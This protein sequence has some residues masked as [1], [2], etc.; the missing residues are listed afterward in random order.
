MEVSKIKQIQ[1]HKLTYYDYP[2]SF[3][4]ETTSFRDENED[5][6]GVM[7]IWQF[8][9]GD[10]E[11]LI[12]GRTWEE[13]DN[14]IHLLRKQFHLSKY[15]ILI[16]Y[17]HN[18]T[19]EMQWIRKRF[20]WEKIFALEERVPLFMRTDTG[21]EFRCSYKLSNASLENLAKNLLFHEI[22]KKVGDLDYSKIRNSET[23]LTEKEMDYCMYDVRIVCAYIAERIQAD[24]KITNIPL[25]ST[26]YV[27]NSCRIACYGTDYSAPKYYNYRDM[28]KHITMEV[29]EYRMIKAAFMGGYCH[30]NAYYVRHTLENVT[31]F[32]FT[33]SYPYVLFS[34][35]YPWTKGELCY[36]SLETV[37]DKR[38]IYGWILDLEI[39]GL[40]S[41]IMQDDYLS[42]SKCIECRGYVLNNGRINYADY[43][44]VIV[45]SV[46]LDIMLQCYR[47]HGGI[48]IN[49]AYRYGLQYLPTDFINEMLSYYEKKTTL[50]DV[51]SMEEEYMQSKAR[52]N[53]LYGMAVTSIIRPTITYQ[54]DEWGVEETSI[55]EGV[56]KYN[57]N[58]KRFLPFICGVFCTAYARRNIWK[59]ILAVG[60]DYVY[61]DTDSIKLLHYED[62]KEFF[63]W[64]NKQV[65]NKLS[66]ACGYHGIPFSKVSP[67]TVE[68]TEKTLGLFDS[69]GFYK[70]FRT[71]GSKRYLVEKESGDIVFTVSGMNKTKAT[72][73]L[74][75]KYGRDGIFEAFID[76]EFMIDNFTVPKGHSGRMVSSYIDEETEGDLTDYQGHTVH[77]HELS[78]INLEES[79]YS[80]SLSKDYIAYLLGVSKNQEEVRI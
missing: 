6:R 78:S 69:D 79:A 24:G 1:K 27:R 19:F 21:I 43:V 77:Y 67:T 41:K 66:T 75:E 34:E 37:I 22:E 7:Y 50:K 18:L 55:E 51:P 52:I 31:S 42:Y 76:D 8:C 48:Q 47:T 60:N 10:S 40:E 26:G 57:K 33:S 28:M 32:D 61:S 16:V 49:R 59:A 38:N 80:L 70:R 36:P 15:R 54:N 20:H 56:T 53:A 25:T 3:D 12:Y 65:I 11:A 9:L 5:P 39:W 64:Y 45:T 68:G 2:A 35:M 17:C 46:D 72:P 4:I 62:H 14:F 63:E 71:L 73:Y 29:D 13:F 23:V 44:H 58:T 74:L 30:A